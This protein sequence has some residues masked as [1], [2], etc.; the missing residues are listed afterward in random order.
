MEMFWKHNNCI[1]T[2]EDNGCLLTNLI[3]SPLVTAR[4]TMGVDLMPMKILLSFFQEI[5]KG[6]NVL[7]NPNKSHLYARQDLQAF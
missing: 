2:K 3:E 5:I 6:F 1:G 4:I 7:L